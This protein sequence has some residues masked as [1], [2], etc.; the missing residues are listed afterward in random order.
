[1]SR[2]K[3]KTKFDHKLMV[4]QNGSAAEMF[5]PG[6]TMIE[7]KMIGTSRYFYDIRTDSGLIYRKVPLSLLIDCD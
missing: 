1:M 7:G 5:V 6:K 4:E 2:I 3:M